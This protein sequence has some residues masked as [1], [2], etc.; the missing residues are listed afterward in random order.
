M[1]DT[2]PGSRGCYR[3]LTGEL[4]LLPNFSVATSEPNLRV[5]WLVYG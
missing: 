4:L 3:G 1:V 2:Y 5:T